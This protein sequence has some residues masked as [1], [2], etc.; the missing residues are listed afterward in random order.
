MA[1]FSIASAA[2]DKSTF[3]SGHCRC[4][5]QRCRC[6]S[7]GSPHACAAT[8]R[9]PGRERYSGSRS[10]PAGRPESNNRAGYPVVRPRRHRERGGRA[11]VSAWI[12]PTAAAPHRRDQSCRGSGVP[13]RA[14]SRA[15]SPA[16]PPPIPDCPD[17]TSVR[18]GPWR[19]AVPPSPTGPRCNPKRID[20]RGGGF[21]SVRVGPRSQQLRQGRRG[22]FDAGRAAPR[23]PGSRMRAG[24]CR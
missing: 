6:Q 18:I 16:W 5:G 15:R 10:G 19:G 7:S 8:R 1:A 11:P 17:P 14:M 22:R 23:C 21:H 13:P 9:C 12:R 2:P 24:S 20:G 4:D 3:I